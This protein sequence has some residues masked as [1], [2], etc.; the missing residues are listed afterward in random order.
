MQPTTSI[1]VIQ[2]DES[3]LNP[4]SALP[5]YDLTWCDYFDIRR[6]IVATQDSIMQLDGANTE[7]AHTWKSYSH[8]LYRF[9]VWGMQTAMQQQ[10][11][12]DGADAQTVD[13]FFTAV[14]HTTDQIVF[15]PLPNSDLLNGFIA[16]LRN[17]P[18]NPKTNGTINQKYLAPLR[19]YFKSLYTQEA[20]VRR[21]TSMAE[22]IQ[23]S[24]W[25]QSIRNT[26]DV[27][28]K[29][30]RK[31]HESA[32]WS[33]GIRLTANQVNAVLR[34]IDRDTLS[35]KRDYALLLLAFSSGLRIAEIRRVSLASIRAEGNGYLIT[36][37]GKRGNTDPV[38]VSAGVYTAILEY[39]YAY[40]AEV[41]P[42]DPRHIDQQRPIWRPIA[43]DANTRRAFA[44]DALSISSLSA[45]I[46]K[47]VSSTLDN[48]TAFAA[49]DT[50][51]T[52][53]YLAY[54]SGM[55]L[56]N[57]SRLLRHADISTTAKYIGVEPDYSGFNLSEYVSLGA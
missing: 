34:G 12:F 11:S 25:R 20:D 33:Q 31:S 52:T 37:T 5:A 17:E 19:R 4:T 16:Y 43:N 15:H 53:A 10:P 39:V 8:A 55:H 32:L 6:A 42:T 22:Y 38:P 21:F 45:T 47:R 29:A 41:D 40:N 36:V 49:H 3:T 14:R 46:K 7:E 2:P 9:F 24:E 57:I 23:Y 35:G 13:N 1:T 27:K 18:G 54:K 48:M 50:R 44:G 28:V 26:E 56:S 51:R 30:P